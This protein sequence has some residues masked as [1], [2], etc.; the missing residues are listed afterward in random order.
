MLPAQSMLSVTIAVSD[1]NPTPPEL[2]ST[3]GPS[4][5]TAEA[6]FLMKVPSVAVI[7]DD[8]ALGLSVT[9][10][11]RA[12]DYRAEH[13][14]SAEAFLVSAH[15]LG[16]DCIIADIQMPGISG[17]ELAQQL[18]KQNIMTPIILITAL[19]YEHLDDEAIT[20]GALCLLRKPFVMELLAGW[21]EKGI[22]RSN[23]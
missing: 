2:C 12:T 21:V 7:D 8:E 6:T 15:L 22:G 19:P 23:H 14:S 3:D 11:M 4:V 18:R 1:N 9:D 16:F 20:A 13:F 5:P 17:I 10:F